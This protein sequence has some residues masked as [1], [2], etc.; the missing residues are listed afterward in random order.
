MSLF[1]L[2]IVISFIPMFDAQTEIKVAFKTWVSQSFQTPLHLSNWFWRYVFISKSR[3]DLHVE[4]KQ[5]GILVISII[6]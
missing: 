4:N 2:Q 5:I 1:E 6:Y 3:T